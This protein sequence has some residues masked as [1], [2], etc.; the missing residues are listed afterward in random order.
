MASKKEIKEYTKIQL[1]KLKKERISYPNEK[2]YLDRYTEDKFLRKAFNMM[3]RRDWNEDFDT[4]SIDSE[5]VDAVPALIKEGIIDINKERELVYNKNKEIEEYNKAIDEK[6][7]NFCTEMLLIGN[8]QLADFA[9]SF[10]ESL[11]EAEQMNNTV[12]EE[13]V[14]RTST[15]IKGTDIVVFNNLDSLDEEKANDIKESIDFLLNKGE[16][17]KNKYISVESEDEDWEVIRIYDSFLDLDYDEY[18]DCGEF[19]Y[20]EIV[21]GKENFIKIVNEWAGEVDKYKKEQ[22]ILNLNCDEFRGDLYKIK[23]GLYLINI[24]AYY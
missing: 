1:E 16:L 3:T 8:G 9:K 13:R 23:K 19:S 18:D 24:D 12:L 5:I 21:K 10:I 4:I 6:Y 22:E 7:K 11:K 17:S 15:F 2:G 14:T 20:Y